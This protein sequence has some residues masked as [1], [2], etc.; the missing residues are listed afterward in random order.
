MKINL[1][2]EYIKGLPLGKF[3]AIGLNA[4]RYSDIILLFK[5][6]DI[7]FLSISYGIN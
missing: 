2:K 7:I 1:N 6:K 3:Q 4:R 5:R